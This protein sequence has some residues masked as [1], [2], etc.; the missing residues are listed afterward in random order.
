M[1]WRDVDCYANLLEDIKGE[2]DFQMGK[3]RLPGAK[4]RRFFAALALITIGG[5][6]TTF[7]AI[8]VEPPAKTVFG[9]GEEFSH[10][11][12]R[13]SGITSKGD[14]KDLSGNSRIRVSGYDP[15]RTG[16]Q[17]IIVD[18]RGVSTTYT[19]TVVGVESIAIAGAPAIA[20]QGMDFDREALSLTAFYG[21]RIAPLPVRGSVVRISG[22]NKDSPGAQTLT[23]EYY[24]KTAAFAVNVAPLTGIRISRPPA[25]TTYLSGEALDLAGL[26]ATASWQGVAD[27][28]VT[29]KYLS[30]FDAATLGAQT[31]IVEALGRQAAFTVTVKEPANP[32]KWTPAQGGF[33]KNITGIVFGNGVF[34][35]AGYNDDKPEESV[36]AYSADGIAWTKASPF[37]NFR[38]GK[39]FFGGGRFAV[40]GIA[41]TD[42]A[43]YLSTSTDGVR[44]G[45]LELADSFGVAGTCTGMAYGNDTL[46]A[47]FDSGRVSRSGRSM[48]INAG[49]G[50]FLEA[51]SSLRGVFFDGSRFIAFDGAGRHIYLAKNQS[52]W[53]L[54]EGS[55]AINGR[56]ISEVV[57]GGGKFIAVGPDNALGWSLDGILWT[58]ADHRGE[59]LRG[60]DLNA[61]DY[62]FGMYVA[63]NSRGNI[64]YSR[65]G[66]VWTKVASSTFGSTR[67]LDVAY[68]NGKFVAIGENGR[69]AYSNRID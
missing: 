1:L 50:R 6:C 5:G 64:L 36:I 13:I 43:N 44:W 18:Y 20:R 8:V 23:A 66:F 9:Q 34:L 4:I 61:V 47:V 58:D 31:V 35:A 62:G 40:C 42:R 29:P 14:I 52:V 67:I 41:G 45:R 30:G 37:P 39:L 38:I 69:I 54:G 33:A 32:E 48:R 68:G 25:K 46:V 16:E 53:E 24:G 22:Y 65:D 11:G 3:V 17:T 63:V 55:I 26:E 10:Q 2:G 19:I 59:R 49:E 27:A 7:Q 21:D 12:L 15:D 60:G 51:W 28:P 56:P 57:F